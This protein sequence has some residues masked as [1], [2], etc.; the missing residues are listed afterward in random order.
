VILASGGN[1][2]S[3]G[4]SHGNSMIRMFG[5]YPKI[6]GTYPKKGP[7]MIVLETVVGYR[8]LYKRLFFAVLMVEVEVA[9]VPM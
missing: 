5:T 9:F 8:Y 4:V 7:K 6:S 2:A 3:T 1:L